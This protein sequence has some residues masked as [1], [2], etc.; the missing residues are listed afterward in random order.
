M[1]L[2]KLRRMNGM[3]KLMEGLEQSN[4]TR[5]QMTPKLNMAKKPMTLIIKKMLTDSI[6]RKRPERDKCK[7]ITIQAITPNIWGPTLEKT[8]LIQKKPGNLSPRPQSWPSRVFLNYVQFSCQTLR[9]VVRSPSLSP[10]GTKL[11]QRSLKS[12]R[13]SRE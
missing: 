2:R 9:N 3:C 5:G 4:L 11:L 1:L 7:T 12:L 6:K 8:L 10:L 13:I